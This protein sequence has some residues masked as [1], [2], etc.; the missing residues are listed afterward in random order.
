[1]L[2]S[3]VNGLSSPTQRV[4]YMKPNSVGHLYVKFSTTL[5]NQTVNLV[6][7]N[8]FD[9]NQTNPNRNNIVSDISMIP[10][11]TFIVLDNDSLVVDYIITTKN[12]L[13]GL[14]EF[15]FP[16]TCGIYPLVVGLDSSQINP[17]VLLFGF[18]DHG[19]TIYPPPI[20]VELSSSL[21]TN[22]PLTESNSQTVSEFPFA[23]P[24]LLT[25]IMS[26]IFFSR[27]FVDHKH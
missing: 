23:V 16:D 20:R 19:C 4:L 26:L 1:M 15:S 2:L 17:S 13:K 27:Y 14:F 22:F 10:N 24:I 12:N 11:R 3:P 18:T 8:V 25:G 7:L 21:Y 5:H 6:P 9:T